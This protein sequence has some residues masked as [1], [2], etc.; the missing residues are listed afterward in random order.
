M[1]IRPATPDDFP[2]LAGTHTSSWR[3]AY[4][5]VFPDAYLR[6]RVRDDLADQW[7]DTRIGPVTL[8]WWPKAGL[9]GRTTA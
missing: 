3:D 2:A 1:K 9:S 4:R 6:N 7:R 8:C 5:G